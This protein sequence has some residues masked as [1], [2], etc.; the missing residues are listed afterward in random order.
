M[1]VINIHP[2]QPTTPHRLFKIKRNGPAWTCAVKATRAIVTVARE[3]APWRSGPS[4]DQIA[5]VIYDNINR[6][7]TQ[8]RNL[9]AVVFVALL[10]ASDRNR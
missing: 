2:P 3:T 1:R 6:L 10:A 4:A 9:L 5:E 7:S 8:D